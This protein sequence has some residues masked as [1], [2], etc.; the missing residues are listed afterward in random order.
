MQRKLP[1]QLQSVSK[2][3]PIFGETELHKCIANIYLTPGGD[4]ST[5]LFGQIVKVKVGNKQLWR[6]TAHQLEQDGVYVKFKSNQKDIQ[7]NLKD[8]DGWVKSGDNLAAYYEI[9]SSKIPIPGKVALSVGPTPK[10]V[11][12]ASLVGVHPNTAK[13]FITPTSALMDSE[14][15]RH[16]ATT[17]NWFCGSP[18]IHDHKIIGIHV[19]TEGPNP[20]GE[21]NLVIPF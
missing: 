5:G 6:I 12:T 13:P 16:S 15:I 17:A 18:L 10:G 9:D 1:V 7:I 2:F 4:P 20:G 21:N 14:L 19:A 3:G 11:F 8:L